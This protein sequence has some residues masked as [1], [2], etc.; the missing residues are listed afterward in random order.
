MF[1]K[2]LFTKNKQSPVTEKSPVA[3]DVVNLQVVVRSDLG[4]I[5][6]NNEDTGLFYRIADEQVIRE[7]GCLLMVADG[8]GGHQAGEVA[9]RMASEI[10]IREYFNPQKNGG[11]EKNLRRAFNT[12]NTSIFQAA[13]SNKEQQ[14]MGTTCTA[15]VVTDPV[16]HFAHVGDSRAYL[17]KKGNLSRITEDH[18][19]VQELVRSGEISAAAAETHPQRNILTNA[20]GTKAEMK[21]DAGRYSLLF[22]PGD[23]LMLCSDGLYDYLNDDEIAAFLEG[24]DLTETAEQMIATAKKRGGHDNITVVLAKKKSGKEEISAKETRDIDLPVTKEYDLP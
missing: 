6:T 11:I 13:T 18:T 4:N 9:S 1:W 10:I 12:A 14:G 15:I 3:D 21:V 20:M 5:R 24:Q 16:I 2:K 8:M 22:E 7:K 23:R 17:L 19:Y